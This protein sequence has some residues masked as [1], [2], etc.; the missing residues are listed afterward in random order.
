MK[1]SM[2]VDSELIE[3]TLLK[4]SKKLEDIRVEE[5]VVQKLVNT[6]YLIASDKPKD[7]ITDD[8]MSEA[9][10]KEIF[11]SVVKKAPQ[12]IGGKK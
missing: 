12:Y 5:R 4:L 9:R 3:K 7:P 8:V 10:V 6:L 2:A 1:V 11:N